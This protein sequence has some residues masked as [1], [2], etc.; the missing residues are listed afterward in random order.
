[1]ELDPTMIWNLVLTLIVAPFAWAFS[2]MFQ[3]VKRLQILLNQTRE[4]YA[5]RSD[6]QQEVKE[7][8]THLQR[9]EDKIDRFIERNRS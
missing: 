8:I 4:D 3:E 6:V 2:K 9:L 5:K 1:M 7:I